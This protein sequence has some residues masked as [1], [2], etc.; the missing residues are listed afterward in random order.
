MEIDLNPGISYHRLEQ[1]SLYYP[2]GNSLAQDL[3]M[4]HKDKKEVDVLCLGCGDLRNILYSIS[5]LNSCITLNFTLVDWTTE[6]IAR[7]YLMIY[8][9]EH[10]DVNEDQLAALW[11]SLD[12]SSQDSDYW[13]L[14]ME[15]CLKNEK[16]NNCCH[17]LNHVDIQNATRKSSHGVLNNT[18]RVAIIS[19]LN[20][21]FA[22]V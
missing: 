22:I 10:F 14:V 20:V 7:N 13:K 11:Y 21:S 12:L 4:Y 8:A 16:R 5:Q 15:S 17:T 9:M 2:Y 18:Q 19:Q 6:I 1:G 3:I